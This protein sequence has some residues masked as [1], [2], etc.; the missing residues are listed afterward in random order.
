MYVASC[1]YSKQP[2][3]YTTVSIQ[4]IC[5]RITSRRGVETSV[6][7]NVTRNALLI[8]VKV[9]RHPRPES[10]HVWASQTVQTVLSVISRFNVSGFWPVTINLQTLKWVLFGVCVTQC[11][12]IFISTHISTGSELQC[13]AILKRK[14]WRSLFK[15]SWSCCGLVRKQAGSQNRVRLL[16]IALNPGGDHVGRDLHPV[17][18]KRKGV[19]IHLPSVYCQ[20][21]WEKSQSE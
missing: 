9:A 18:Q 21:T 17:T 2:C 11:H 13:F 10:S 19:W 1:V 16:P 3:S 15:T 6:C 5:A 4:F 8:L 7:I 14:Y 20:S 12:L